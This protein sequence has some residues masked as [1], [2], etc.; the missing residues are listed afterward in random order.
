[1]EVGGVRFIE[2]LLMGGGEKRDQSRP[3][4]RRVC[5]REGAEPKK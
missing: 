4:L 1:M 3:A 2:V 5:A